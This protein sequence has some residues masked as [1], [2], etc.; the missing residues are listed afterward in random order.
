MC[1]AEITSEWRLYMWWAQIGVLGR[2]FV[3]VGLQVIAVCVL[4]GWGLLLYPVL[5]VLMALYV[6][7]TR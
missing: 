1:G 2:L 5:Y 6:I 3:I 4:G 7:A